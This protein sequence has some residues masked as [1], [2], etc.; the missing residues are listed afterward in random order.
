L[1]GR[2][3]RWNPPDF[4]CR[5]VDTTNCLLVLDVANLYG[6]SINFGHDPLQAIHRLPLERVAYV[7]VAGGLLRDG[8]WHDS[9][10]GPVPDAV[11]ELVA[12]LAS[13]RPGLPVLLE[14][15]D[16]WPAASELDSELDRLSRS[17][18]PAVASVE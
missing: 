4:L 16:R 8:V 15:D 2:I 17:L 18:L 10:A 3:L 14:R 12:E 11:F 6:D 5:V 9:H 7:H 1:N 13:R